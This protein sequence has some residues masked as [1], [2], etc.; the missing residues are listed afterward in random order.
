MPPPTPN[1]GQLIGQNNTGWN[2]NVTGHSPATLTSGGSSLSSTK[3]GDVIQAK[4]VAGTIFVNHSNVR[5]I[6]CK[7]WMIRIA[8]GKAGCEMRWCEFGRTNGNIGNTTQING[9]GYLLYRCKL[10]GAVDHT[11]PN[12]GHTKIIE[13][14]F[15]PPWSCRTCHT[16]G[17][18]AHCDPFQPHNPPSGTTYG[19]LLIQG[20]RFDIFP[21]DEGTTYLTEYNRIAGGNLTGNIGGWPATCGSLNAEY[22]STKNVTIR[23]NYF[24]GNYHQFLMIQNNEDGP[25]LGTVFI[26]NILKKRRPVYGDTGFVNI[27]GTRS[28]PSCEVHWRNNLDADTGAP[29]AAYYKSPGSINGTVKTAGPSGQYP[30]FYGTNP[31][32]DPDPDPNPVVSL[33][34]TT[35]SNGATHTSGTVTF[36]GGADTGAGDS[37]ANYTYF[38]YYIESVAPDVLAKTHLDRDAA[39]ANTGA[40]LTASTTGVTFTDRAGVTQSKP[41]GQYLL[42]I[43]GERNDGSRPF[44]EVTVTFGTVGPPAAAGSFSIDVGVTTVTD[45]HVDYSGG[46]IPDSM[47][48]TRLRFKQTPDP[49]FYAAH[50]ETG[51]ELVR[52][53]GRWIVKRSDA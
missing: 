47:V 51:E 14:W 23:D 8:D 25:I 32:P 53:G 12:W 24:D 38:N 11:R 16:G 7:A 27:G 41:A 15:G 44:A 45:L 39:G 6:D 20:N 1:I 43:E 48:E 18:R 9:G 37:A 52:S 28:P 29:V 31:N 21:F 50:A 35:P 4:D 10:Y 26:D 30:S 46:G 49:E 17:A 34:V 19:S 5:V 22:S 40:V 36:L 3:D 33:V 13:N 2:A 42:R